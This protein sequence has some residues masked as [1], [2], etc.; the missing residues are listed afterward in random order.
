MSDF[1]PQL[2]DLFSTVPSKAAA[3]NDLLTTHCKQG[4]ISLGI[5]FRSINEEVLKEVISDQ[6]LERQLAFRE[7]ALAQ[8]D[9][10][11]NR[12]HVPPPHRSD[13]PDY[14]PGDA[15][16]P[17]ALIR[18]QTA[19]SEGDLEALM[20]SLAETS[21][22]RI[23]KTAGASLFIYQGYSGDVLWHLAKYRAQDLLDLRQEA[24]GIFEDIVDELMTHQFEGLC[25]GL[26]TKLR[27]LERFAAIY[28]RQLIHSTMEYV[29][30]QETPY[31]CDPVPEWR[32][33]KAYTAY[34]QLQEKVSKL[35]L[36][37][38]HGHM[39]MSGTAQY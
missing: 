20:A 29:P 6:D 5:I 36:P 35:L 7:L 12:P 26:A 37:P 39:L 2:M 38:N 31:I 30:E 15:D 11:D 18:V 17:K 19:S 8:R 3:S 16:I 10:H 28:K 23:W 25:D 4:L 13:S 34:P 24:L 14:L 1:L 9:Q 22:L 32:T 33:R 21:S 27:M